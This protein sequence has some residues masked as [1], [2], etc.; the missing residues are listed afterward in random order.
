MISIQKTLKII[1]SSV[2]EELWI[3]SCTCNIQ[4]LRSGDLFVA[5]TNDK[6]DGY[7]H[8]DE[9][10]RRG[11]K[12]ILAERRIPGIRV[13]LFLV[14]NSQE[15]YGILC[16]KLYDS[17]ADR[18]R[19]TAVT[20]TSGKTCTAFL[21]A[22]MLAESGHRVGLISSLG[23]YDGEK[24]FPS[25]P[26]TPPAN[27]LAYWFSRML[28]AGCTDV[29]LE[30]SSDALDKNHLAGIMLDAICLTNIRVDHL[31]Y[32]QT[33]EHYR[34][35]K[36]SIFRYAKKDAIVV[37]N[38]DDPVIRAVVP[39]IDHPLLTVGIRETAEINGTLIERSNGDQTFLLTAGMETIPVR[40][41]MIGDGPMTNCLIAAA[42]GMGRGIDLKKTI[43][44]L[45]R[46]DNIPGRMERINCGQPF[47]VFLD[48]AQTPDALA[49]SLATL[50]EITLGRIYCVFGTQNGVDKEKMFRL[51]QTLDKYADQIVLTT[52]SL[53]FGGPDPAIRNLLRGIDDS[54]HVRKFRDR[55]DAISWALSKIEPADSLLIISGSHDLSLD[56]PNDDITLSDR[57]LVKEWLYENQPLLLL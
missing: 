54:R 49:L 29:V 33:V 45:E 30:V 47:N 42:C 43:R 41:R 55:T 48:A 40:T 23:I 34:R 15:A 31:D 35:T 13:P 20:G 8:I 14:K 28:A 12:A 19:I 11:C 44:G 32:H 56:V 9:A 24:M 5:L 3:D 38:V 2:D 16:Q 22:G 26:G 52:D 36:L 53:V 18:L 57:A 21:I 27:E 10:Q 7:A 6:I 1:D 51:G 46:V 25:D 50:R 4:T 17:P 39:L 37:C